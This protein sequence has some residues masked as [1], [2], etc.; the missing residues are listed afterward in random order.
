MVWNRMTH[1]GRPACAVL[2]VTLALC[3]PIFAQDSD[4]DGVTDGS[5]N[6]PTII[7]AGQEDADN[8]TIGDACDPEGTEIST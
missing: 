5:D 4:G 8:D 2:L 7:N 6:C 1:Q 3:S